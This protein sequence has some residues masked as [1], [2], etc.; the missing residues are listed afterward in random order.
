[1]SPREVLLQRVKSAVAEGNRAGAALPLPERGNVGY[2][3]AGPDPVQRFCQELAAA[4][5]IGHIA[6]DADAAFRSIH[7]I[8]QAHNARKILLTRGGLIERLELPAR[9]RAAGFDVKAGDDGTNQRDDFFAAEVGITNVYRLIAETGTVVVA[10][11]PNEPRSASLLPPVHIALADRSQ[12][13]PDLFDLFDLFSPNVTE[14]QSLPPSCL[15]LITGP[16]KTGDIELKLVTGVHG[17]GEIHVIVY[18]E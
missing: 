14:N 8:L 2:Q 1:M 10:C 13:L 7:G 17:P 12:L 6:S 18:G 9:L 5:G 16:S 15:S 11:Q 4:G 3:G